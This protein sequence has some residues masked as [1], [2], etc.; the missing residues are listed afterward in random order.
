MAAGSVHLEMDGC[1]FSVATELDRA[2]IRLEGEHEAYTADKLARTIVGLIEEGLDVCIDL[3]ETAF[4]DSTVIGVLLAA[5][6]RAAKSGRSF[7]LLL[8]PDTGWPVHRLLE[9]TRL[10]TQFDVLIG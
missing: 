1:D 9:V 3:R 10:E 4:I 5:S 2:V 6:R 8:G 7:Q